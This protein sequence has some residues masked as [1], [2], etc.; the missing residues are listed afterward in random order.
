M[1][2]VLVSIAC[3]R[4]FAPAA[5]N[6]GM[7]HVSDELATHSEA[8]GLLVIGMAAGDGTGVKAAAPVGL[9]SA[10]ADLPACTRERTE[11][12]GVSLSETGGPGSKTQTMGTS[13]NFG[14]ASKS[15]SRPASDAG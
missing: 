8:D 4:P 15:S 11:S 7:L 10:G 3:T 14:S 6:P 5:G 13:T 1:D 12:Q 9:P 2:A